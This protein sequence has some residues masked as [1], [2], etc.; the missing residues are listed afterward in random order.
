MKKVTAFPIQ[1]YE[2]RIAKIKKVMEHRHIDLMLITS[3]ENIYYVSGFDSIGYYQHQILFLPLAVGQ[4][5]LFVQAV[6]ETLVNATS[7]MDNFELWAHG[8]DPVGKTIDKIKELAGDSP[9]IGSKKQVG[10]L[11]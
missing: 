7:W 6:E 3:P 4:P 5:M 8:S 2:T 9:N 10:G 1:E 11:K